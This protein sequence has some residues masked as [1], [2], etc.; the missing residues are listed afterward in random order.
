MLDTIRGRPPCARMYSSSSTIAAATQHVQRT[1]S[2]ALA[3]FRS[4]HRSFPLRESVVTTLNDTERDALS[5]YRVGLTHAAPTALPPGA[6]PAQLR[7]VVQQAPLF[8]TH[9]LPSVIRGC[10]DTPCAAP[11]AS[12]PTPDALPAHTRSQT[13]SAN[14][15]T[16][17][18]PLLKDKKLWSHTVTSLRGAAI[19]HVR[20]AAPPTAFLSPRQSP[21]R[22]SV[23]CAIRRATSGADYHRGPS[24]LQ[25]HNTAHATTN[26]L[27]AACDVISWSPKPCHAAKPRQ[28]APQPRATL[29]A[30]AQRVTLAFVVLHAAFVAPEDRLNQCP[31]LTGRASRLP[32]PLVIPATRPA[33]AP[34]ATVIPH[35]ERRLRRLL[36]AE[37]HLLPSPL[38]T[39]GW[40]HP[41]Q[42]T[43][44]PSTRG[45]RSPPRTP[46]SSRFRASWS[47][48]APSHPPLK[49]EHNA[50]VMHVA[51][52]CAATLF[53]G[54]PPSAH[55][56]VLSRS[57]SVTRTTSRY[58]AQHFF[59]RLSG[60]NCST[61]VPLPAPAPFIYDNTT[62][63][64]ILQT[65]FK[66]L[67][68]QPASLICL[69]PPNG[70][71]WRFGSDPSLSA[72][73]AASDSVAKSSSQTSSTSPAM[74]TAD[75]AMSVLVVGI[76]ALGV[77][78]RFIRKWALKRIES[79]KLY[80]S[81]QE[82]VY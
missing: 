28:R 43:N 27:H 54:A 1:P 55:S 9:A 29:P 60:L 39:R 51:Y 53:G 67:P 6:A 3:R 62:S 38:D 72:S 14:S 75:V 4:G 47:S 22:R 76:A 37:H 36:I 25:Y 64:N 21:P 65:D 7:Y 46:R 34:R 59:H 45:S 23:A 61:A 41:K 32:R 33:S 18:R 79:Q 24:T 77:V 12:T 31:A 74:S 40:A 48:S 26:P 69:V 81:S 30:Y 71:Y 50:R 44:V 80:N 56:Q 8:S 52:P 15:I 58:D 20:R 57:T 17:R 78:A 19:L 70:T 73:S 10:S 82:I 16:R 35:H 66:L 11:H 63:E 49:T 5:D 42:D 68:M 2:C 13:R